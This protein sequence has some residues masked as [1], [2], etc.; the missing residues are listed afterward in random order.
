[1]RYIIKSINIYDFKQIHYENMFQD[2]TS[3]T[4][5]VRI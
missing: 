4:Y 5:L 2:E 1:M 3:T